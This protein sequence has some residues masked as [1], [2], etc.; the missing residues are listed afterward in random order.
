[1]FHVTKNEERKKKFK[2]QISLTSRRREENKEICLVRNTLICSA[3]VITYTLGIV[4]KSVRHTYQLANVCYTIWRVSVCVGGV[5]VNGFLSSYYISGRFRHLFFRSKWL[6][7]VCRGQYFLFKCNVMRDGWRDC[8]C[9]P[10]NCIDFVILSYYSNWPDSWSGRNCDF[11]LFHSRWLV[12]VVV[13][14]HDRRAACSCSILDF[15]GSRM[16]SP[17]SM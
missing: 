14:L 11:S 1:M 4:T 5:C 8:S 16:W 6:L 7:C 2:K 9:E 15:I 10:V 17:F 3:N 13:H 12:V